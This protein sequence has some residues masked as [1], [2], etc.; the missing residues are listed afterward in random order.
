MLAVHCPQA[1]NVSMHHAVGDCFVVN[2]NNKNFEIEVKEA[3]PGPAISVVE[4]D[5]Q[6][7]SVVSVVSVV[8]TDCQ[9]I[10]SQKRRITHALS[11][12]R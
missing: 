5:C 2:Y 1:L 3:K 4:T 12:S 9:V 10:S 6:V 11:L 8:K 7:I